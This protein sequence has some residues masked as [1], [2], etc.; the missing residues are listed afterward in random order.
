MKVTADRYR[1]LY[2]LLGTSYWVL[3]TAQPRI[4]IGESS[5]QHLAVIGILGEF[6]FVNHA[7]A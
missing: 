2:S 6:E 5:L 4:Q 3:G 7:R 1:V